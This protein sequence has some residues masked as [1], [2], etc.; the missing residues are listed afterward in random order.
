ML[1]ND[2]DH[3]PKNSQAQHHGTAPESLRSK[4]LLA[5]GVRMHAQDARG[6]TSACSQCA[7]NT[8]SRDS[9]FS[10]SWNTSPKN[11]FASA[12]LLATISV[13]THAGADT[14]DA[15]KPTRPMNTR[16]GVVNHHVAR[17]RDTHVTLRA[18]IQ[19]STRKFR[20][21]AGRPAQPRPLYTAITSLQTTTVQHSSG[22]P[23]TGHRK[24]HPVTHAVSAP[25]WPH[26]P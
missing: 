5:A 18:Q 22:T 12:A 21:L 14:H 10:Q 13:C 19:H 2:S 1:N 20:A 8:P 4:Q 17:Q 16:H 3:A 26:S 7:H 9:P 11:Y 23:H 15:A 25:Q 6:T 24:S